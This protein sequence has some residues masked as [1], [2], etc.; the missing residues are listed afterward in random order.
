MQ[1]LHIYVSQGVYGDVQ[2]NNLFFILSTLSCVLGPA[3]RHD[4]SNPTPQSMIYSTPCVDEKNPY[5]F[6]RIII[7]PEAIFCG[8][9]GY[10]QIF[11]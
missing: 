1:E 5:Y 3:S 8:G 4:T 7:H 9:L 11:L 6:V 10:A 2:Y